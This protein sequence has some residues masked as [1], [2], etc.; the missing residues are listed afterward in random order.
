ML[1]FTSFS[2][3]TNTEELPTTNSYQIIL[4]C[5]KKNNYTQH[6]SKIQQNIIN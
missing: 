4:I 1:I 5:F 6:L 3:K 2:E